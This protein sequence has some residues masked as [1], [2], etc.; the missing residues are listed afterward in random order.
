MGLHSI[1]APSLRVIK[2]TLNYS[3]KKQAPLHCGKYQGK[4]FHILTFNF[5]KFYR[6][7][8]IIAFEELDLCSPL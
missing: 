3:L 8:S 4:R 7:C 6:N 5:K 1:V 2:K